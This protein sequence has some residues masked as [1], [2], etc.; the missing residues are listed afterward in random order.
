MKILLVKTS[1]MGDVVHT[2]YAVKEAAESKENIHIDWLVESAFAD[3]ARLAQQQKHV[4]SVIPVAFRQ[5]RKRK[6]LGIFLHPEIS[7]L[8]QHLRQQAYDC[9]IDAQGLIK[10]AYLARLAG[11]PITGFDYHSAREGVAAFAYQ[12]RCTVAKNQHAIHRT[13]QLFAQ[14]LD[15][16]MPDFSSPKR[17]RI[18]D[19]SIYFLHGTTW[20]NKRYPTAHWRVLA[21]HFTAAGYQ[22]K[23]PWHDEVEQRVAQQIAK[24]V[25][26]VSILPRQS[27][28]QIAIQLKKAAGAVCVDT[29]LAHLAAYLGVPTVFL[30]GPTRADLTGGIGEN[31]VN[32]TGQATD[33]RSM[34]RVDYDNINTFSASMQGIGPD[35]VF[36]VFLN[37]LAKK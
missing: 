29:G 7:A 11:A 10:S 18:S 28:N 26:G 6:P 13:R 34:K 37:V 33:T 5:W 16:A 12:K 3:V 30:F 21:K 20:A 17:I 19:D 36:Q 14:A 23:L 1:S 25:D 31:T 9:V 24:G 22:V 2:L 8:K 27:I 32:I 15:Y 4:Q 35:E